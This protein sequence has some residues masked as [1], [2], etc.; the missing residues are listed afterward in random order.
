LS[1]GKSGVKVTPTRD[2]LSAQE[3]GREKEGR[4]LKTL[5]FCQEKS[6][7]AGGVDSP[8]KRRKKTTEQ[9]DYFSNLIN[10]STV[11]VTN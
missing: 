3:R 1:N 11:V 5:G 8:E 6:S 4:C 9:N 7:M 10:L 2:H